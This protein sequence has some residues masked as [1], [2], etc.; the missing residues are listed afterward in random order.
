MQPSGSPGRTETPAHSAS[1]STRR[2]SDHLFSFRLGEKRDDAHLV[3]D[4]PELPAPAC[5]VEER[6]EV[7]A[8]VVRTVALGVVGRRDRGH[9]V[10]VH[11][12]HPEEALDLLG[13]LK[14]NH[15]L[16]SG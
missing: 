15:E 10:A 13:H 12:V 16:A 3:V 1:S 5:V 2:S 6:P 14:E 9:L 7:E 11:R 8:V 4:A